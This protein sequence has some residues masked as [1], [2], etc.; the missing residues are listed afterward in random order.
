MRRRAREL[1]FKVLFEH[2]QGD[3]PLEE[4][5]RHALEGEELDEE[6]LAFARR[7]V[8]GFARRAAEVDRILAETVEGW[9]FG[10]MSKTDLAVLRLATYEMLYEDT[11]FAPLI[12]VAVKIAGKYGGEDSGKFVNGVLAR[13]KRRIDAGELTAA[14]KKD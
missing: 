10:Q 6:G 3:V 4:A 11:P 2:L 12:E 14:P 13:L 8:D 1:A 9:D 7:L 5:W